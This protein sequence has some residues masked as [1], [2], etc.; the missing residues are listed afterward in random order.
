MRRFNRLFIITLI[1]VMILNLFGCRRNIP[2]TPNSESVKINFVTGNALTTLTYNTGTPLTLPDGTSYTNGQLK[3]VWKYISDKLE[4]NLEDVSTSGQ[5]ATNMIEV[6]AATNF[7]SANIYGG[8]VAES[9]MYYGA[10]GLFVNLN[11]YKTYLPDFFHYLEEYPS[12]ATSITAYDGGIYHIPYIAE[13]DEFSRIFFGRFS[14]VKAL[15]DSN[16]IEDENSS[17]TVNYEGYWKNDL[18]RNATNVIER[19]NST[20]VDGKLTSN[21]ALRVLKEYIIETYP[22][23]TKLSDLYLG[24]SANYDIDELVALWRVIKLHPKTLSKVST[25]QVISDVEIIP[26]F[27][28]TKNQRE[29][30]FKLINYFGGTRT[31]G[32]NTYTGKWYVDENNEL[33]YTF[34]QDSVFEGIDYLRDLYQ[35][36]LINPDYDDQNNS[37][38][39]RTVLYGS[40]KSV[41]KNGN[42]V[43]KQLGFMT[44]DF[45]PS[46]ASS[47]VS[48]DVEAMLPPLTTLEGKHDNKFYH[49]IEMPRTIMTSGWAVS[50]ASSEN[51]IKKA[52]SLFNYLFTEEGKFVQN[53]GIP[54]VCG[55]YENLY[56]TNKGDKVPTITKWMYDNANKYTSGDLASFGQNYI[57]LRLPVGYVADIGY[58]VQYM[59]EA[60]NKS[61]D[62]YK[63]KVLCLTYNAESRLLQ[64]SSPCFSLTKQEKAVLNTLSIGDFQ[65][66][67]TYNYI[68]NGPNS[69]RSVSEI[70]QSY[71]DNGVED[72]I[73][74]YQGAY[75]R[76]KGN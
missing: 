65:T 10:R 28:R 59:N 55:D 36:G 8:S 23:L 15:L 45:I 39:Y 21:D 47:A 25:G 9:F 13:I 72:F 38:N 5:S 2:T 20:M 27:F 40:D 4:L 53:F 33:Q 16:D 70:K 48:N 63:D 18:A 56:T 64:L 46:T 24:Q 61:Y 37:A 12:I 22:T 58:E 11:D 26:Y 30:L 71:I 62:L 51:Q 34:F 1:F 74:I 44:F 3:P 52:L 75:N 69:V 66:D 68:K 6:N 43:V 57:G 67:M 32:T 54:G 60:A 31:Y 49:Y 42:S 7:S 14:W 17:L 73:E 50:S 29:E 35:E 76:V 41:D 19:Q